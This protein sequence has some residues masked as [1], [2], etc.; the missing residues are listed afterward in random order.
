MKSTHYKLMITIMII[1]LM[2][3]TRIAHYYNKIKMKFRYKDWDKNF[4]LAD[5]GCWIGLAVNSV[6]SIIIYYL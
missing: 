2:L 4:I 1:R 6:N 3:L 5:L